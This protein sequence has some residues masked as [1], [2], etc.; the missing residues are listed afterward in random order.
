VPRHL[1][2]LLASACAGAQAQAP[3][4]PP[5]GT[6]AQWQIVEAQIVA[7]RLSPAEREA[8]GLYK[9][10]MVLEEGWEPFAVTAAEPW[11]RRCVRYP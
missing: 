8:R 5:A 3:V 11:V 9:F 1:V 2:V 6:C 10:G 7:V 4:P